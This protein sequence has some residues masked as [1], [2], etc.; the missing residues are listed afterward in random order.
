[1]VIAQPP[2]SS[3]I[4]VDVVYAGAI[5]IRDRWAV[6]WLR[7]EFFP[8]EGLAVISV[9]EL[10]PNFKHLVYCLHKYFLSER[11]GVAYMKIVFFS[12][13]LITSKKSFK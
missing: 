11:A 1:M 3:N 4:Q 13:A 10:L 12:T 8:F 7:R 9:T 5:Q 2:S 6:R